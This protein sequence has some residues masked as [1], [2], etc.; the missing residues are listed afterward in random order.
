MRYETWRGLIR[1][2]FRSRVGLPIS[3]YLDEGD[4]HAL[5]E[6]GTVPDEWVSQFIAKHELDDLRALSLST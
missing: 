1:A 3:E 4:L 6:A 2:E 5:W